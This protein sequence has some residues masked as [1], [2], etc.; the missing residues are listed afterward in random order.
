MAKHSIYKHGRVLFLMVAAL[1]TVAC[2]GW[3]TP[4]LSE[5]ARAAAN[6]W[7]LKNCDV[8]EQHQLEATLTQFKT[9]LEPYFV[10]V[11][12]H[13]PDRQLLAEVTRAAQEDFQD[14]QQILQTATGLGVNALE[15]GKVRQI[16]LGQY[17]TVERNNFVLR[18]KSRA[19]AGLGVVGGPQSRTLLEAE[20]R[21]DKSP[22]RFTALGAAQRLDG[23]SS[24]SGRQP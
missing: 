19:L 3:R 18:Y 20:T 9:E 24:H 15:T 13:G 7:L 2:P 21:D 10:Y 5:E 14:E 17:I 1:G 11:Y 12:R 8:G 6:R 22:L 16:T 23:K 4:R